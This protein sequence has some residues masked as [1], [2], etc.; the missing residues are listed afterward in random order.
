MTI[1]EAKKVIMQK[2]GGFGWPAFFTFIRLFITAPFEALERHVPKSG[3]IVDLG[4]GYGLF[5]NLLSLVS[6]ERRVLG[7]DLDEYKIARAQKLTPNVEFS[8]ADITKTEIPPADCV[9]LIHVLHH[10]NSY[11]EQ[12]PLL[13]ACFEKLKV[14]GK[15]I[16][17]EIQPRPWW[18][19]ILT[20][21]ADRILYRFNRPYYPFPEILRPLLSKLPATVEVYPEDHRGTPFSHITY[22]CAKK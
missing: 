10:L 16:I 21:I 8:L 11:A 18:K 14:G 5:A 20:K 12:E 3:L 6:D 9:L 1:K 7:M 17:A 15:L 13:R 19:L 22:V 4:C 2:Y